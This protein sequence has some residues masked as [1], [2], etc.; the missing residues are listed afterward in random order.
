VQVASRLPQSARS[1]KL[2]ERLRTTI[3]RQKPIPFARFMEQA[4]YEPELGYYSAGPLPWG[5]DGDYV[6][7]PQVH[8]ALGQ[9]IAAFATELDHALGRPD[10]F[11]LLEVGSGNGQLARAVLATIEKDTPLLWERLSFTSVERGAAALAAQADLPSPG[12]GMGIEAD[13]PSSC[14]P[15]RGLVY[16]NE[17][18]DAFPVHRVK[19]TRRGLVEA[20]V[21]VAAEG[22]VERYMKPSTP[23]LARYIADNSIELSDDQVGEICLQVEPWLVRLNDVLGAGGVLAVDYGHSTT[24]L[25][26]PSRMSGSLVAQQRFELFDDVLTHPGDCDLTAHVDF[27]NLQRVG[28]LLAMQ[29][30]GRCS[31]RVFLIGMGA[32]AGQETAPLEA[33]LALRHLLVSEIAD[34]HSVAFLSKKLDGEG[35][36]FGRARLDA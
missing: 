30:A 14:E 2:E 7:A 16:A 17:F 28:E 15:L 8:P 36:V 23:A 26:G 22:L 11:S 13:L 1:R 4:L 34:A 25:Y 31:L 35:P 3:A 32:T 29:W 6:T 24:A 33:R 20:Y 19:Q 18:F 21:D 9:S 27:G 5:S 12:A 10:P